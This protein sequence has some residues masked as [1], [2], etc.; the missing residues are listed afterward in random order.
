MGDQAAI[1]AR[2][3]QP[4]VDVGRRTVAPD[5]RARPESPAAPTRCEMTAVFARL[6]KAVS[7]SS[8]PD[9]P[10]VTAWEADESSGSIS[11]FLWKERDVVKSYRARFFRLD[12][13]ILYYYIDEQRVGL[14]NLGPST[15]PRGTIYLAGCSITREPAREPLGV[16]PPGG[17]DEGMPRSWPFTIRHPASSEA[18]RLATDS[19]AATLAW[20]TMLTW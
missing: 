3:R 8:G 11:G 17:F 20:V 15:K 7:G 10:A 9:Q 12:R 18:T 13:S 2:S 5:Q 1:L 14:P 4:T 16:M 6:K 19:E